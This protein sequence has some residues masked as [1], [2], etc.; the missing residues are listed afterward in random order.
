MTPG[1][2]ESK[3]KHVKFVKRHT[4]TGCVTSHWRIQRMGIGAFSVN[5]S[6]NTVRLRL[7]VTRSDVCSGNW[8]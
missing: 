2:T 6:G 4:V 7:A 8:I 5:W 3:K 1:V